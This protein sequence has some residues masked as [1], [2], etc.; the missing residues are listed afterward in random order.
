MAGQVK[1]L[2]I[3][4]LIIGIIAL[5]FFC[6]PVVS[7]LMATTGLILGIS[8]I[9]SAKK[10]N[11]PSGLSIAGVVLSGMAFLIGLVFNIIIF[12][13]GGNGDFFNNG[14]IWFDDDFENPEHFEQPDTNYW[15]VDSLLLNDDEIEN[16]D[17]NMD[18]VDNGPGP[19]PG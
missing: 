2:G 7:L 11:E 14:D 5:L 9:I 3:I 4:S 19:A 6:I 15:D 13:G 18:D 17:Q 10:S 12:T 8:A 1:T 16:L